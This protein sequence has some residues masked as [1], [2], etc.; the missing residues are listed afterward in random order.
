M[1]A[2]NKI[3]AAVQQS[4]PEAKAQPPKAKPAET[5]P[6]EKKPVE[7]KPAAKRTKKTAEAE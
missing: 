3:Q 7:K 1:A 4:K 6:A 2:N 5:K